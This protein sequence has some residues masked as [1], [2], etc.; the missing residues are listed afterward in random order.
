MNVP[1][2]SHHLPNLFTLTRVGAMFQGFILGQLI[3]GG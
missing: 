1:S 2:P 3:T